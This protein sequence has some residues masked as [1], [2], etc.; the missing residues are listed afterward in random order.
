MT[1]VVMPNI[2]KGSYMRQLLW[3][4]AGPGRHNEHTDQ[5]I[6][7]GDVVTMAVY[8][9]RISQQQAVELARLLDSPRQI[10]LRGEPVLVTDHKQARALIAA[11]M[12]RTAAY[13]AATKDHNTWHCSLALDPSEGQLDDA[14][15]RAIANDFMREMGFSARGDG[16]PDARWAAMHHGLNEAGGDHIHIAMGVV[17]PDGSLADRYLDFVRAQDACNKLEHKYGLQV[18]ASREEG[19]AERATSPAERAR[20]ERLG[21]PETDKEALRRRVRALAVAAGSEAEWIREIQAA[22]IIIKPY[23]AKGGMDEVTGYSVELPPRRN[24]SGKLEKQITYSGLR[25]AKDLTLPSIRTWA[26][27]DRSL[28]AREEALTAWREITASSHQGR[29][30]VS[31]I[32]SRMS[33]QQVTAELKRFSEYARS[34]PVEDRDAWAKLASQ[35]AG[36]FEVLSVQTETRPGPV[37]KLARQLA[38]VGQ[39]GLDTRRPWG[40][41]GSGLRHVARMLWATKSPQASNLALIEAMVECLLVVREMLEATDRART[42]AAMLTQTRQALTEIHM[43][44]A[45]LEPTKPYINNLGSPMWAA[46]KRAARAIDGGDRAATEAE[47]KDAYDGWNSRRIALSA[48]GRVSYDETG[49]IVRETRQRRMTAPRPEAVRRAAGPLTPSV[50]TDRTGQA[51]PPKATP[52]P[53][54][55][56]DHSMPPPAPYRDP[57]RGRGRGFER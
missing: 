3:Y 11:G 13:E 29:R 47:I 18:L 41:H 54:Q 17:R 31:G 26:S 16:V 57:G 36:V 21:A 6:V 10:L 27:W 53:G 12:D 8:G 51:Q 45:G 14:T 20:A 1:S 2:R 15:W 25:L 35:S 46:E 48:T 23:F 49:Q 50:G 9:G 38:R 40:V 34:I 42:A 19:G 44:A 30:G 55:S 22:G 56:Y 33:E 52:K 43:R 4:L 5:R 32:D 37:N 24:Q 28:E 39:Q 7:G